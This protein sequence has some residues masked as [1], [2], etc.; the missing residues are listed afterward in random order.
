MPV[1]VWRHDCLL[2][3]GSVEEE[4]SKINNDDDDPTR[5][6][7]NDDLIQAAMQCLEWEQIA[8]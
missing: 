2:Q 1:C 5:R 8:F 7:V 4:V 6:I 3:V